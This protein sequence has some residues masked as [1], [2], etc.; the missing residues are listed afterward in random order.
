MLKIKDLGEKKI[1]QW[2]QNFC[3]A[4]VIGDD[5]ALLRLQKDE[6][7]VITTDM[8]VENVHFSEQTTSAFDVGWRSVA[9]N[10]SDLAAMGAQPL[11]LTVAL[12]LPPDL[13]M[14]WLEQLYQGMT[15]FEVP[16]LGGD[17]TRSN[18]ITISI[19]ALG[20]IS[21]SQVIRR[22]NA[23]IGDL[24]VSTGWH[25]LSRAG[26]Y[27][28]LNPNEATQLDTRAHAT[29]L[30][31]HQRPQPRLDVSTI[32]WKI[33][34]LERVAGMDSSDGLADAIINI[35]DSSGVGARIDNLPLAT[36]LT[37]WLSVEQ[38][39]EWTLY[40]GEDFQL[41]LT[42]AEPYAHSLVEQLGNPAMII[43]QITEEKDIYLVNQKIYL[44]RSK[45]FQHF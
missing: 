38:A 44:E 23:R 7:L 15:T 32:L 13:S 4:G 34:G 3:P 45:G 6:E 18:V 29:M 16:I 19:T 9:A 5:A 30:Q 11:G 31:A 10:L 14:A 2:L 36:T 27:L 24:I 12:S 40:G 26:L 21:P 33:P 22:S 41:I 42:L 28:L 25:G 35:C 8:L 20:G 43:G 17:L 37:D 39:L 1:L